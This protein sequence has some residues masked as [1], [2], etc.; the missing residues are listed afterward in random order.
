MHI[1]CEAVVLFSLPVGWGSCLYY[2]HA[3]VWLGA[4]DGAANQVL[5]D[6]VQIHISPSFATPCQP[7]PLASL[8]GA[9]LRRF[10]TEL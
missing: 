4:E 5:R 3:S 10:S 9:V 7:L 2:A 1:R 6:P 8:V